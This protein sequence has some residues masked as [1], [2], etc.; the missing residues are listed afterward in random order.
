MLSQLHCVGFLNYEAVGYE[1]TT[2]HL[3]VSTHFPTQSWM[4]NPHQLNTVLKELT[5][6]RSGLP[7]VCVV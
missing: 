6:I 3:L 4:N 5:L 1:K 2:Y 7:V